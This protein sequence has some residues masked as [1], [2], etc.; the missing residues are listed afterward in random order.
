MLPFPS[1]IAALIELSL[2]YE[3]RDILRLRDLICEVAK[4]LG[5]VFIV[6]DG[7][8]ECERRET[9]LPILR[10]LAGYVHLL[11]TS[12]D[13]RDI[14]SSFEEY[15]SYHIAIQPSDVQLDIQCFVEREIRERCVNIPVLAGAHDLL[16]TMSN[17]LVER[18]EGM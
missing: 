6:V 10:H 9:L 15:L 11:V 16:D 18:A 7:L 8:D 17:V 1:S 14:R 12:R 2:P 5:S 4:E 3:R 13:N